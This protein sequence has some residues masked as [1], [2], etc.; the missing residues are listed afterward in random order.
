MEANELRAGAA[1]WFI[2]K[3]RPKGDGARPHGVGGDL[4]WTAYTPVDPSYP[5][6]LREP[7]RARCENPLRGFLR[8]RLWE[9]ETAPGPARRA[10]RRHRPMFPEVEA[11]LPL[12]MR[13]SPQPRHFPKLKTCS[14]E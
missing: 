10:L 2:R 11:L 13:R 1:V 9:G 4:R 12:L 14:I 6:R 8:Q 3:R 7:L 5:L